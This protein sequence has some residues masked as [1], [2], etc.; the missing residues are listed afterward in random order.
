[1]QKRK[2][3]KIDFETQPG[4]IETEPTLN[5]RLSFPLNFNLSTQFYFFVALDINIFNSQ[6]SSFIFAEKIGSIMIDFRGTE[7]FKTYIF[8]LLCKMKEKVNNRKK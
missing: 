5:C 6:N 7:V 4:P 1:M 8:Q 3:K 2:K